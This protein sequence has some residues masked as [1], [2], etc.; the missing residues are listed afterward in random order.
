MENIGTLSDY[1]YCN[2][3][4][5]TEVSYG[6]M[7]T[8]YCG[9][10]EGFEP[11]IWSEAGGL[12][13]LGALPM[14][15]EGGPSAVS[16]DG[17]V[18][19]FQ[20]R[21]ATGTAVAWRWTADSGVTEIAPSAG[22]DALQMFGFRWSMSA[23]GSVAKGT[24]EG[25]TGTRA[26]RL[27]SRGLDVLPLPNGH[28]TSSPLG[29]S[30]DGKTIAGSSTPLSGDGLFAVVWRGDDVVLVSDALAAVGIDPGDSV[31]LLYASPFLDNVLVGDAQTERGNL[32]WVAEL[33]E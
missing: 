9:G 33:S 11:F 12:R 25:A 17:R 19:L 6:P 26:V 23:D 31:T 30:R 5:P 1:A 13:G 21:T 15:S 32:A 29:V 20:G 10:S 16:E 3:T 28:D 4:F 24:L 2:I 7:M 18:A 27:T 8:G 14:E 22:Y